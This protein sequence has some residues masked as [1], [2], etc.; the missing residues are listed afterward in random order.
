MILRF[1]HGF[2]SLDTPPARSNHRAHETDP[3]ADTTRFQGEILPQHATNL[4]AVA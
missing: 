2:A 3:P 1:I 4:K